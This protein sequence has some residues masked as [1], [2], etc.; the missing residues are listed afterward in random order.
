[1]SDLPKPDILV[2]YRDSGSRVDPDCPSGRV[3]ALAYVRPETNR[4]SYEGEIVRALKGR[5]ELVYMAN[6]NGRLFTEGGILGSHYASQFRFARDPRACL[7]EYPEVARAFES[8]FGLPAAEADIMG[9]LRA[10][11][12]GFSN[13]EELFSTIVDDSDFLSSYGQTFKLVRGKYIVNYD[14]PAIQTRYTAQSD[15]FVVLVRAEGA[16]DKL[17]SE[18]NRAIYKEIC[19]R[20]ETPLVDSEALEG[21]AWSE[22]VRRTYHLSTNRLMA[23]LDM[24]DFV[25]LS[26]DRRLDVAE[27]PLGAALVAE[28]ILSA[29][30]L[31]AAHRAQ[32]CRIGPVGGPPETLAYLPQPGP[33]LGADGRRGLF[34]RCSAFLGEAEA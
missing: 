23:M 30:Q 4:S 5:A 22:R 3:Y 27:T 26:P 33:A 19:S 7:S 1:M 28:G 32:L 21:M 6:L 20:P 14:I 11:E 18:L 2:P 13:A 29:S 25:Y 9:S 10:V 31:R 16:A 17:Y 34:C 8:H 12:W 24:A 15:C